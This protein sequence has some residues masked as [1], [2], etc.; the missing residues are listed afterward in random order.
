MNVSLTQSQT[1]FIKVQIA[2]GRYESA[3]EVI[4]QALRLLEADDEKYYGWRTEVKEKVAVGIDKMDM[5]KVINREEPFTKLREKTSLKMCDFKPNMI[6]YSDFSEMANDREYQAEALG[7]CKQFEQVDWET[8][9][10][11]E[12]QYEARSSV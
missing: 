10:L 9:V 8:L 12:F 3:E 11:G 1:E 4:T 6:A 2:N 7:I 5:V